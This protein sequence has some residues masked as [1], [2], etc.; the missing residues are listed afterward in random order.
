M[1]VGDNK[2]WRIRSNQKARRLSGSC[3]APVA[4]QQ[5]AGRR[6][7]GP[8][9]T[10]AFFAFHST[11]AGRTDA[12][13]ANGGSKITVGCVSLTGSNIRGF[14]DFSAEALPSVVEAAVAYRVRPGQMRQR[15]GS[16]GQ[17]ADGNGTAARRGNAASAG[18]DRV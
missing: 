16:Q 11:H 7:S 15:R 4:Q 18:S 9:A 5:R 1:K 12:S 10:W 3:F 2:T 17:V 13:E 6:G 8:Q 14:K